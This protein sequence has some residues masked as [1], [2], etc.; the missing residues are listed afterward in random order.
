MFQSHPN[1]IPMISKLDPK[2]CSENPMDSSS[3]FQWYSNMIPV[4]LQ[5]ERPN[6]VFNG[7]PLGPEKDSSMIPLTI[8]TQLV[9]TRAHG[10]REHGRCNSITSTRA[11]RTREYT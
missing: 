4:E 7:M 11:L 1:E 10:V 3:G 8:R 5:Q 9:I 6:L 2:D